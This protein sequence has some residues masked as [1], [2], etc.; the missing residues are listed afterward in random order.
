MQIF[1]EKVVKRYSD[2][3]GELHLVTLSRGSFKSL[4]MSLVGN[5]DLSAM[6]IFVCTLK[7]NYPAAKS[8]KIFV[9]DELLEVR[10]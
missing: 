4:G 10:L 6:S 1:S 7:D 9:G 3:K 8:G 5:K 2:L